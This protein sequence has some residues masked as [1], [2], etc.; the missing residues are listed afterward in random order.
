MSA[1]NYSA[2][3][4]E[5][6]VALF[7]EAAK[8]TI[9]GSGLFGL[10]DDMASPAPP[11]TRRP[12]SQSPEA[13][14]AV[15]ALGAALRPRKPIPEIRRLFED[16]DRDVR[17]CAAGQFGPIDPEWAAATW[18]GLFAN[19][20]TRE[21]LAL[22]RR[23][24]QA[25][26][27]SP[28]LKEMSDDAVVARFEDAATREYATQFLDCSGDPEDMA[29]HNRIAG[30]LVDVMQELKSRGALAKLLPLLSSDN[31]GVRRRAAQGCMRLAEDKAVAALESVV[32]SGSFDDRLAAGDVLENWHKGKCLVDG[33]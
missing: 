22:T 1:D 5:R 7:I 31:M 8:K 2:M 3:S 20:P 4:T 24:R 29:T 21:V 11:E 18:S 27:D 16:D 26:P 19:L 13:V 28:T 6:L 14:A 17:A 33:L 30:E 10:L 12:I 25:P 32:A 15:Q 23:A 9:A